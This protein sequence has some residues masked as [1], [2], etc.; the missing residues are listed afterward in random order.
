MIQQKKAFTLVELI[1]TLSIIIL[2][3]TIGLTTQNSLRENAK[4]AKVEANIETL[5]NAFSTYFQVNKN[6]LPD[7]AGNTNYFTPSGSYSHAGSETNFGRYGSVTEK[8]LPK[9]YLD[10]LPLD[11]YTGHYYK[12]GQTLVGKRTFQVAGVVRESSDPIALVRGNY[13][14][15][16][17]L[18]LDLVRGYNTSTFVSDGSPLVFPY[19]PDERV[20][21]ATVYFSDTPGIGEIVSEWS[22]ITTWTRETA[23][24]YFS[25]GSVSELWENSELHLVDF[26]YPQDDSLITRVRLALTEGSI[27]TQAVD[28]GD[29]SEF[30][31]YT[32]DTTAAVRGTV[33]RMDDDGTVDVIEGIV[34][35]KR[36]S[37]IDDVQNFIET[38]EFDTIEA[39]D[40]QEI[41]VWVDDDGQK[42]ELIIK[43]ANNGGTNFA[44]MYLFWEDGGRELV[45][46][47]V[48]NS[49]DIQQ[50]RNKILE[51]VKRGVEIAEDDVAQVT[52]CETFKVEWKCI[53]AN[54]RLLQEGYRLV[55]VAP[56]EE[57][58]KLYWED[59]VI[60][61]C[62]DDE[63]CFWLQTNDNGEVVGGLNARGEG[64]YMKYDVGN[65]GLGEGSFVVEVEVEGEGL[66]RKVWSLDSFHNLFSFWEH[67]LKNPS[68]CSLD[69]DTFYTVFYVSHSGENTM[70]IEGESECNLSYGR[71]L[72]ISD[73]L[74][75][76][77]NNSKQ[78][79]WDGIIWWVKIYKKNSQREVLN[80]EEKI[81]FVTDN[82]DIDDLDIVE[83]VEKIRVRWK[84]CGVCLNSEWKV[85]SLKNY[86]TLNGDYGERCWSFLSQKQDSYKC[87]NI[88]FDLGDLKKCGIEVV[89][90]FDCKSRWWE[91]SK[92]VWEGWYTLSE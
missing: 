91:Q 33:F 46:T 17:D 27:F 31:I 7:V 89:E 84:G 44:Q 82:F 92:N 30:E 21:S 61:E 28:L 8:T 59:W 34:E 74:Y 56:Y 76:G 69:E 50:K 68:S 35:I 48:T 6:E 12:Y 71:D 20:M 14:S 40:I 15:G 13:L 78:N 29:E 25:D 72:W 16:P 19:N 80:V 32:G 87:K 1:I 37:P 5:Q 60:D 18:P 11:P 77:S 58:T 3:T 38:E 65:L 49:S 51:W 43:K 36:F 73:Y 22:E 63:D 79:K 39:I 57:D 10:N 54:V 47:E 75:I 85:D 90:N 81:F 24:I 64:K 88:S 45:P 55:A 66:T 9:A 86:I 53:E 42:F 67:Y 52:S 2:L 26:T 41:G 23:T 70:Y 4:N 83:G 62:E